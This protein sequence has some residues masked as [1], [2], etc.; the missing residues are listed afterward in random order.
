MSLA[1]R[2]GSIPRWP[3]PNTDRL[4]LAPGTRRTRA[5]PLREPDV[6]RRV[7]YRDDMARGRSDSR[8]ALA[9][10]ARLGL[11]EGLRSRRAAARLSRQYSTEHERDP[12]SL[13]LYDLPAPAA[14][15][16]ILAVRLGI[17]PE[18]VP[19]W[20]TLNQ[21]R[22]I[23]ADLRS[24]SRERA[25]HEYDAIVARPDQPWNDGPQI[26]RAIDDL[27]GI[28]A[29]ETN[30]DRHEVCCAI[31]RSIGWRFGEAQPPAHSLSAI[32]FAL[33][34]GV[35]PERV[36]AL[37]LTEAAACLKKALLMNPGRAAR[38]LTTTLG[39]GRPQ[40]LETWVR[41]RPIM[42]RPGARDL[43]LGLDRF[44][45]SDELLS[46][47]HPPLVASALQARAVATGHD[48]DPQS[49]LEGGIAWLTTP[50][51]TLGDPPA[52]LIQTDARQNW[53]AVMA[54]AE[55]TA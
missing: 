39:L 5:H 6:A 41:L 7:P 45:Y 17:E 48:L 43:Y 2:S 53:R 52:H 44:G 51:P 40:N 50:H 36:E 16:E 10:P 22:Q 55:E 35:S 47:T 24:G 21:A 19:E 13:Y 28:L 46:Y 42:A 34:A 49:A 30:A 23:I 32:Q 38:H 12:G 31:G 27:G 37:D 26:A 1:Y 54:A 8:S 33:D 25:V 3:T 4:A 20:I 18:T 14:D 9:P 29:A 15:R 11:A